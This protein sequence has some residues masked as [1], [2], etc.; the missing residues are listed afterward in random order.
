MILK[1]IKEE[2]VEN[3]TS[4]LEETKYVPLI[5]DDNLNESCSLKKTFNKDGEIIEVYLS[6][7]TEHGTISYDL[8]NTNY[9]KVYLMNDKGETIE[10]LK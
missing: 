7:N 5:Q 8:K 6:A 3:S 9:K 10:R 1:I 4:T 2:E